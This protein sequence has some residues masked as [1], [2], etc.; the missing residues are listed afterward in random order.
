MNDATKFALLMCALKRYGK[1]A[2]A[3][4]LTDAAIALAMDA[5]WTRHS[6][7][8][9]TPQVVAALLRGAE[10][11]SEVERKGDRFENGRKTPLWAPI[12]VKGNSSAFKE[13]ELAFD[14]DAPIPPAPD[15]EGA[16]HPLNGK[17]KRQQYVMFD[18]VDTLLHLHQ[19]LSR[20]TQ[21]LIERHQ[22]DIADALTRT[23]Q[24]LLA[25]GCIE[26]AAP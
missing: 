3:G 4:D 11:R 2:T 20:E 6:W 9:V 5:G 19:R 22:R 7:Q 1:P 8:A 24:Q 21:E 16:D 26:E 17:T 14:A 10:S 23:K 12:S 15:P 25:A 18:S 13:K